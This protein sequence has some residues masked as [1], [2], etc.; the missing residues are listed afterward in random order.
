VTFA[1]REAVEEGAVT[2]AVILRLEREPVRG[3]WSALER[4]FDRLVAGLERD[5]PYLSERR[6]ERRWTSVDGEYALRTV[7]AGEAR[8]GRLRYEERVEVL[9]RPLE[10]SRYGAAVILLVSPDRDH[11]RFRAAFEDVVGSLR[12]R[13]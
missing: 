8:A 10:R 1:P 5:H 13:G 2:H 6:G 9:L 4:A 11:D 7:L 12:F 3:G